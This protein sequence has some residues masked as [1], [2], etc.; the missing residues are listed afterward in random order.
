MGFDYDEETVRDLLSKSPN[1]DIGRKVMK[2]YHE[3]L[4]GI[5]ERSSTSINTSITFLFPKEKQMQMKQRFAYNVAVCLIMSY[6]YD[7]ELWD[8][9]LQE[10]IRQ[11]ENINKQNGGQ[12]GKDSTI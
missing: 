4:G 3:I 8:D 7:K 2:I 1:E 9:I 10:A 11:N 12:D 5:V 6:G